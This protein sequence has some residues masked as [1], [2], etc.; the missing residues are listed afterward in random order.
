MSDFEAVVALD[1]KY[2][3][4]WSVLYDILL[5]VKTLGVV[6]TSRGAC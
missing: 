2:Q 3:R 1:L 6:F 4:K 5:I